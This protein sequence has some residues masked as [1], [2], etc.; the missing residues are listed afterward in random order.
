IAQ[1][2]LLIY[3]TNL[4]KSRTKTLNKKKKILELIKYEEI[5]YSANPNSFFAYNSRSIHS[6]NDILPKLM[7]C[8]RSMQRELESEMWVIQ[9]QKQM[10]MNS[11]YS[12]KIIEEY[13]FTQVQTHMNVINKLLSKYQNKE[14]IGKVNCRI[15]KT[16]CCSS[17]IQNKQTSF[18]VC[19]YRELI[20][21]ECPQNVQNQLNQS[22]YYIELYFVRQ[23][24]KYGQL[25]QE[26]QDFIQLNDFV[27]FY[28]RAAFYASQLEGLILL[29]FIYNNHISFLQYGIPSGFY[30]YTD[31]EYESCLGDDFIEPY[32]PRCIKWYQFAAKNPGNLD[33]QVKN[34]ILIKFKGFFF[35]EPYLDS[36]GQDRLMTLSTQI[37]KQNQLYSVNS[38][39][40]YMINLG[41]L[42][43]STQTYSSYSVLLHEF[44]STVFAHPLLNKNNL[45][46]WPDL[47]YHNI[48]SACNDQQKFQ[49]CIKQK[50]SFEHQINQTLDFIKTGNYSLEQ[51]QNLDNLHQVFYKISHVGLLQLNLIEMLQDFNQATSENHP[52]KDKLSSLKSKLQANLIIFIPISKNQI[53]HSIVLKSP[54]SI[55]L[56]QKERQVTKSLI[57]Y[58]KTFRL[59]LNSE[60]EEEQVPVKDGYSESQQTI[61]TGK[62]LHIHK[63]KSMIQTAKLNRQQKEQEIQ[64]IFQKEESETKKILKG[65]KPM[66]LE[67]K[68]NTQDSLNALFHFAKAKDFFLRLNNQT[69]LSRWYFNLGLI[70]LLKFEYSLSSEYFQSVIQINL[71]LIREDYQSL[72]NCKLLQGQDQEA[73][74]Q[75]IILTKRVFSFA[76]SQKCTA[77]QQ[78]YI[79]QKEDSNDPLEMYYKNL[80]SYKIYTNKKTKLDLQQQ[81]VLF[82][83]KESLNQF[84][85]VEKIIENHFLDYQ[86]LFQRNNI[87]IQPERMAQGQIFIKKKTTQIS[88]Y[89]RKS[90]ICETYRSKQLFL[91]GMIEQ[92]RKSL[93]QAIEYLTQSLEISTHYDHFQKMRTVQ[94]LAKLFKKYS[95]K[96]DFVD[97]EYLNTEMNIPV[98]ITILLEL[99]PTFRQYNFLQIIN[100]FK[101][102][103]FL[104]QN[105]RIQIIV[106]NR[107]INQ[108][109]PNTVIQSSEH[110]KVVLD[111][112]SELRNE[113]QMY[114]EITQ[115]QI[116]QEQALNLSLDFFYEH[117]SLQTSSKIQQYKIQ[118]KNS[119][120]QDPSLN[121]INQNNNFLNNQKLKNLLLLLS[122]R[123]I[124]SFKYLS[125]Q[126][127]LKTQ[128]LIIYHIKDQINYEYKEY[129]IKHLKYELLSSQNDL[130][131]KLSKMRFNENFDLQGV[132]LSVLNNF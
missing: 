23:A 12:S 25:T 59:S 5:N 113:F 131:A 125:Q 98:D 126:K 92:A 83:L 96:Q 54:R 90:I 42:F 111:S 13:S 38:I 119:K 99:D 46:C 68:I 85:Q 3:Q 41:N 128:S 7:E 124:Q 71:N 67:M 39:D 4:E 122:K 86:L 61:M 104:N 95:L 118:S 112:L 57:S 72:A 18:T 11:I 21:D 132:F 16:P 91:L 103:N 15:Y 129:L 36:L 52:T 108:F 127:E 77:F 58:Q 24:L 2:C 87:S 50:Q 88:N 45:T 28:G 56:S 63:N 107:Q 29:A 117:N 93:L 40:I 22:D 26:Q 102:Y 55:Q 43:V 20:F 49:E 120:T 53:N 106:Y 34:L 30:N 84:Q 105:D 33:I 79:E 17:L 31:S 9:T 73:K 47:E 62:V 115:S 65:L 75:L 70:H 44:N 27:S 81:N 74:E 130:I 114:E 76:Y 51:N 32:D 97:E 10:L 80:Y 66:F 19:S 60:Q 101:K 37:N 121:M 78:I 110:W 94:I 69:G 48:T 35:F 1:D 116:Q 6:I 14:L 89:N 64:Q 82:L 8:S 100:G 109:M 123:D